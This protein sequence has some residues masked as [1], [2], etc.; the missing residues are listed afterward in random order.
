MT[1]S[2]LTLALSLPVASASPTPARPYTVTFVIDM[3]QEI[4]GGRFQSARDKVGVRGGVAPLTWEKTLPA[5]DPDGD[6]RYEVTV[7]FARAPF[8]DQAGTCK[9]KVDR[10]ADP[11]GGWED[12]RNRQ[13]FLRQPAQ[14]VTRMFNTPRDPVVISRVGTIRVHASFPSRNVAPRDVQVYLPPGYERETSRRY[15]VLYLHDGQ[16]VFNAA[17]VGMEWQVDETAERLIRAGRIQPLIVVAVSNTEARRDEYTPTYVERKQP[18]GVISKGGG[19]AHLYG[20]FLIEELK[21]FIDRTYRTLVDAAN[22]TLGGASLGGLV[23]VWLALEHPLVFGSALAV[24]P[25]IRWDDSVLLKKIA[26]LPQVV[27]VRVWVDIGLL[28][29]EEAVTGARRLRDALEEKGWRRG[30][31]LEY[32]EQEGGQHDEISWGSRVEE[33]LSFL[34]NR[35]KPPR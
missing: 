2:T 34:D 31:D 7:S 17:S 29:G 8:G 3:R 18:D 23:S 33:M 22:T 5:A 32:L 16:N 20:R 35:P 11:K 28:E 6:G 15:P 30:F 1:V 24:S 27:P 26:A 10:T 19:K 25:A 4:A 21:P 12:G 13:L 14:T 9:F